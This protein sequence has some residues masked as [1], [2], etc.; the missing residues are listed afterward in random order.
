MKKLLAFIL[1]IS[2]TSF[3]TDKQKTFTLSLTEAQL[4]QLLNVVD[5]SAAPHLTVKEVQYVLE[6]QIKPQLDSL[7]K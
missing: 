6:Q 1:I 3:K 7:K 4:I 2:L 5:Q